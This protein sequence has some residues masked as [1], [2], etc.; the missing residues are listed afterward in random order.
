MEVSSRGCLDAPAERPENMIFFIVRSF[1][2]ER[3]AQP[4]EKDRDYFARTS[5]SN[6]RSGGSISKEAQIQTSLWSDRKP[7]VFPQVSALRSV[8]IHSSNANQIATNLTFLT[9]PATLNIREFFYVK[10]SIVIHTRESNFL[11]DFT[12]Y[13]N[14]KIKI[15]LKK[16]LSLTISRVPSGIICHGIS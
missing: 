3:Y 11:C 7:I 14:G 15:I 8:K 10:L 2:V 16:K 12:L 1:S 9:T 6:I 5:L 4:R 13:L